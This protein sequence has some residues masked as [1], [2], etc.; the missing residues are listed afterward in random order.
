MLEGDHAMHDN[1]IFVDGVVHKKN[2][3]KSLPENHL[4]I[5]NNSKKRH[6]KKAWRS[7]M[8]IQSSCT[9]KPD[10]TPVLSKKYEQELESSNPNLSIEMFTCPREE[11]NF[12]THSTSA[13]QKHIPSKLKI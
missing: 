7:K 9:I 8:N 4:P 12:K 1:K 13:L 5:T 6:K 2:K 10:G 11:C 3:K